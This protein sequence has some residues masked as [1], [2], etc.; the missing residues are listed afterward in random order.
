[1]ELSWIFVSN[2]RGIIMRIITGM[3]PGCPFMS[4]VPYGFGEQ[5][6]EYTAEEYTEEFHASNLIHTT[7]QH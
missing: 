2:G 6:T 4:F 3:K 7:F 5:Y 1:M